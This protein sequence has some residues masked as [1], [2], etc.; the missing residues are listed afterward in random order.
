MTN[1]V[2]TPRQCILLIDDDESIA[3]S[4]FQYLVTQGCE[5]DAAVDT[6]AA[7]QLMD[8][9]Q[10]DVVLVDP[11][12]TGA[13]QSGNHELFESIRL[14]QPRT[15]MIVLT[16]YDSPALHDAAVASEASAI[17]SKPQ[18]VTLLSQ[19]IADTLGSRVGETFTSQ[20]TKG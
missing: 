8:S 6:P 10:Y 19:L 12:L 13:M 7:A 5:V 16:A 15:S 1:D 3:G 17:L 20:S 11:Y 18:S 4:L 2:R 14:R 9:R